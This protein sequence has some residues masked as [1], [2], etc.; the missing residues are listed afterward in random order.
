MDLEQGRNFIHSKT[1]LNST[2]SFLLTGLFPVAYTLATTVL[3]LSRLVTKPAKWQ[4]AQRR[5]RSAWASAQSDQRLRFALSG[6]WVAKDPS[7]LHANNEYS[8]QAD[9]SLRLAH[10]HIIAFVMRRLMLILFRLALG[11]REL[12]ALLYVHILW[13]HVFSPLPLGARE[14]LRSLIVELSGDLSIV[15]LY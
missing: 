4:C 14:G 5:L 11:K 15:F 3:W 13:F 7:F 2:Q 8:D 10:N 9:L 12:V 1:S 6:Q